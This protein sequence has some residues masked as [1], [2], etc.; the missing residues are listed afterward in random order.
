MACSVIYTSAQYVDLANSQK[1]PEW[2]RLDLGARYRFEAGERFWTARFNV[3]N[4][5]GLDY[6]AAAN[7]GSLVLGTP[8][9]Y[10]LSLSVD[11]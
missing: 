7:P 9:T 6:W 8:R 5:T 3:E 10:R 2:T 1:I 11:L 4:G